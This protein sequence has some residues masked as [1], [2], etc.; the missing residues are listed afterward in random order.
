MELL[1]KTKV[2]LCPA[3]E[4]A[5]VELSDIFYEKKMMIFK[6]SRQIRSSENAKHH[7]NPKVWVV[8]TS[9]ANVSITLRERKRHSLSYPSPHQV[10]KGSQ[11][12][13]H[14]IMCVR[15]VGKLDP[16]REETD[17]FFRNSCLLGSSS[18]LR[19]LACIQDL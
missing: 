5:L 1:E 16:Q 12:L 8:G 13:V 7:G 9:E 11:Q 3:S 15:E 19:G 2:Q 6:T 10:S 4:V 17:K 14:T 18:T